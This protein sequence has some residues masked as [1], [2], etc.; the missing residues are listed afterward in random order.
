LLL[1]LSSDRVLFLSF[2][3]IRKGEK[4]RE[5][6]ERGGEGREKRSSAAILPL[7][8]THTISPVEGERRGEGMRKRAISHYLFTSLVGEG[9]KKEKGEKKQAAHSPKLPY[10]IS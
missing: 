9:E 7:T 1:V 5:K 6:K 4:G 8:S 10:T 3:A 2:H